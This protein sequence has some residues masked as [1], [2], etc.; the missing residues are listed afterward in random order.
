MCLGNNALYLATRTRSLKE[1]IPTGRGTS[2]VGRILSAVSLSILPTNLSL[3]VG[4]VGERDRNGES[5]ADRAW[6]SLVY[7]SRYTRAAAC[8]YEHEKPCCPTQYCPSV[9]LIRF[10]REVTPC[11][12]GPRI[13][14]SLVRLSVETCLAPFSLSLSLSLVPT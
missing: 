5:G 12:D 7:P 2:R 11:C 9:G 13:L 3:S 4:A 10:D 6:V 8:C 14:S 1:F